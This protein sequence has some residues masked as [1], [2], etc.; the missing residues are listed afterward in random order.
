MVASQLGNAA[1]RITDTSTPPWKRWRKIS[2]HGR[3]IRFMET[4]CPLPKGRGHGKP[5]KLDLFQKEFLEEA[6]ADKVDAAILATGRGNGK[7]T[8]GGAL[9]VWAAFD[10][11]GT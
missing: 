1:K 9:A 10:D 6:L 2:R 4:Y 3:A 11:E 7:S 5:I 8:G